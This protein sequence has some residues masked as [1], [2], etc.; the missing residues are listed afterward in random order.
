VG[1][2]GELPTAWRTP[3]S[4]DDEAALWAACGSYAQIGA[5]ALD[6]S[7]AAGLEVA[8]RAIRT[9]GQRAGAL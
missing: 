6:T 5:A 8:V 9:V 2:A 4:T 3:R 1:S 7:L